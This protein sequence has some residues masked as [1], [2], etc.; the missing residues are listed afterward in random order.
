MLAA[1]EHGRRD[2][3]HPLGFALAVALD[4]LRASDRPLLLVP[5]PTRASAARR[6]GGDPV[7]RASCT[8]TG[9]LADSHSVAMLRAGRGVRDSVGL[10]VAQRAANLRGRIDVDPRGLA[11]L[12]T[13]PNAE[14]VLIDDVLTTG[15]T[16]CESVRVLRDVGVAAR[17]LVTVCAA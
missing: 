2:L 12:R 3:A 9:W 16:A 8:A 5:A 13:L 11:R 17:A 1:K 15:A 14:V 6:R 7:G 10:S 4:R